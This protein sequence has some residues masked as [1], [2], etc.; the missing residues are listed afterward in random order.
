MCIGTPMG[1]IPP[2]NC[3]NQLLEVQSVPHIC[4]YAGSVYMATRRSSGFGVAR[5]LHLAHS[6]LAPVP[7]NL[8]V[9]PSLVIQRLFLDTLKCLPRLRWKIVQQSV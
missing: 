2:L 6:F 8:R 4:M 3:P 9:R 1:F 7:T 5:K